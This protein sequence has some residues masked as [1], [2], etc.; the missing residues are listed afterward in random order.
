[1]CAEPVEEVAEVG[2]RMIAVPVQDVVLHE[3]VVA[4]EIARRIPQIVEL[5]R[6][7][8]KQGDGLS[9]DGTRVS[10]HLIPEQTLVPWRCRADHHTQ[11]H[12]QLSLGAFQRQLM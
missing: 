5:R 2:V 6:G 11:R 7:E 10:A 9:G 3:Q 8:K 1:M 4:R 12:K